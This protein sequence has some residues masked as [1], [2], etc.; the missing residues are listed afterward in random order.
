M[1]GQQGG[2]HPAHARRKISAGVADGST[3]LAPATPR[4]GSWRKKKSV[5]ARK[6][7]PL[8]DLNAIFP[9]GAPKKWRKI[10]R[11]ALILA[12]ASTAVMLALPAASAAPP[13]HS[14][15][16]SQTP[17]WCLNEAGYTSGECVYQSLEQCLQDR[18]G[19]GGYC[20]PNPAAPTG[21]PFRE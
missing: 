18:I 5:G 19:E 15:A 1:K 7:K 12:A 17:G 13:N 20:S 6:A 9:A 10:M 3:A 16:R 21:A 8:F 4:G 14:P 2:G 11:V